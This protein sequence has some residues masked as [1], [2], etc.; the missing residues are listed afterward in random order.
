[1]K[2]TA[3]LTFAAAA[4]IALAPLTVL[5]SPPA[6]AA[7]NCAAAGSPSQVQLCTD[8]AAGAQ[9][10]LCAGF[11]NASAQPAATPTPAAPPP[12]A[13]AAA[14]PAQQLESPPSEPVNNAAPAANPAPAPS[15]G[16]TNGRA[17]I[18]P[19]GS[20]WIPCAPGAV[21]YDPRSGFCPWALQP[22]T[23]DG[24]VHGAPPLAAAPA[25]A[26]LAPI[27]AAPIPPPVQV[28]QGPESDYVDPVS[29]ASCSPNEGDSDYT[30]ACGVRPGHGSGRDVR[31]GT[32]CMLT[33]DDPN[34]FPKQSASGA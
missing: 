4:A 17:A 15:G 23:G 25:A 8:C 33:K 26:P 31:T 1:M 30:P 32:D 24:T 22:Y 12:T 29:G 14:P 5:A 3:A 20:D 18:N 9:S 28:A 19:Y 13:Q 11:N 27:P 2:K 7:P 16:L 21:D 6:Q 10:P 34:C